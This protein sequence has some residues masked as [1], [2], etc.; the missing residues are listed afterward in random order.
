MSARLSEI[1]GM[2]SVNQSNCNYQKS[3]AGSLETPCRDWKSSTRLPCSFYAKHCA[4]VQGRP[5][6]VDVSTGL[7]PSAK[8]S[9]HLVN[10]D[11]S[12]SRLTLCL[13]LRRTSGWQGCAEPLAACLPGLAVQL[14]FDVYKNSILIKAENT[15]SCRFKDT[16][17][18]VKG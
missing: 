15:K 12:T 10:I 2:D 11:Y 18:L 5:L 17:Y 4:K 3:E 13:A 14:V 1:Q 8:D 16:C 9:R 6:L 7:W